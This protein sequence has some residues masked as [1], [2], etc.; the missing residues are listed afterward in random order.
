MRAF[1]VIALAPALAAA[2]LAPQPLITDRA[3]WEARA[4]SCGFVQCT[5]WEHTTIHH[6]ADSNDY[7]VL[8]HTGCA[9]RVRAHQAF[10]MDVNAWCDIGYNFLVCKHGVAFE[11]REGSIT[12]YPRG[13]HDSINCPGLGVCAMGYFHPPV[14][15]VP[16]PEQLVTVTDL[17]A[18][19]WDKNAR[20]PYGTSVYGGLVENV[21]GGHRDVSA[22]ACP[23]DGLWTPYIGA[24]ASTG[25]VRDDVCAKQGLCPARPA[26][27]AAITM[28]WVSAGKS[29]FRARAAVT[30]VD[31]AGAPIEGATVTGDFTGRISQTGATAVSGADGVAVLTTSGATN[32][33]GTVTFTVT[34]ISGPGIGYDPSANVV[35]SA[36][37]S[38]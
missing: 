7:Q 26:H 13:A 34:G 31:V 22:T 28:A 2:Q 8:D 29:R 21:I 33:S 16:A 15:D 32:K 3:G 6:T 1:A 27:V 23:G 25:W 38:R 36:S 17:V 19:Q 5:P 20:Q 24:D 30:V 18:W 4:P 11:G 9:A 12:S 35:T 10:H 37:L 14:D